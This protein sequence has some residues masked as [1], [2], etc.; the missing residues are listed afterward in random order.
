[1]LYAVDTSSSL[2]TAWGYSVPHRR[3]T[4]PVGPHSSPGFLGVS[5][6]QLQ[7]RP[8]LI[9]AILAQADNPRRLVPRNDDSTMGSCAYP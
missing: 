4:L 6:G 5:L 7:T 3:L 1:M 2:R 9:L 8:A